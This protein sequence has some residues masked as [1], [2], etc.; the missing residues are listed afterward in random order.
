MQFYKKI[1]V[2]IISILFTYILYRQYVKRTR[3]LQNEN[4]EV[5]GVDIGLDNLGTGSPEES[6]LQKVTKNTNS[7]GISSL[8]SAYSDLSISQYVIKSSYNTAITGNYVNIDM[9]KYVLS[10][11]CRF[12]DFEVYAIKNRDSTE[13]QYAPYVAYSTDPT[14]KSVDTLNK[15]LLDTI[16]T[17]AVAYGF[18]DPSPN[19]NDPLFIQLRI[20]SNNTAIYKMVAKSIK[21]SID[22]RL[23]DKPLTSKTKYSDIKGK[24]VIVIDKTIRY[25]YTEYARCDISNNTC[26]DLTTVTNIES[27]SE[28]LRMS[29]Y[30]D[31]L[32]KMTRPPIIKDDNKST[33]VR[34]MQLV[35]PTIDNMNLKNPVDIGPFIR[36]YGC[37]IVTYRYYIPGDEFDNYEDFFKEN[38]YGIVPMSMTLKYLAKKQN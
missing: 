9:L 17:S 25:D 38:G 4:F 35:V 3:L 12:I 28:F 20:K 27:G 5:L 6:E 23:Y 13:S 34:Y 33:N 1:L 24:V 29:I 15:I 31:L 14:H 18:N 19:S 7:I 10:R 26:I 32:N 8:D 36:D 22:I 2:F 11:G 16:L 21:D 30:N 37:Q